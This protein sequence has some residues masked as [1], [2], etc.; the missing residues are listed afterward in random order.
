MTWRQATLRQVAEVDLGRQRAPEHETGP[1]MTRYLRAANVKDGRLELD[2]VLSMNFSPKEQVR[3]SLQHGDVL[4]TEGSGS[5][6][7]VGAS[8][9]YRSEFDG[10]ICFQNT[11]LRLRPRP[12]VDGRFLGWWTRSA[13]T[14]GL[15]AS[16][17]SGANIYHISAERVRGLRFS[18][19]SSEEQRR[20]ADFLDIETS[21]V[22][23]LVRL[24]FKQI[25]LLKE[26]H[27][28]RLDEKM[29]DTTTFKSLPLA[30]LTDAKRPIQY[31][32]VLPGPNYEN[33][34]PIL[35]GGDVAAQRVDPTKLSRTDPKIDHI[36]RRSR[37]K[38][39]D[40]VMAIRGSIG[41]IVRIP[42]KLNGA[43]LTQDTARIAPYNVDTNWLEAVLNSPSIQGQMSS[44]TTG[45]TIKGINIET[46][47]RIAI[48][49]PSR[50][51]QE[52]LGRWAMK[53]EKVFREAT[54]KIGKTVVALI[55]RRQ[56][57]IT[58]AVNGQLDVTTMRP[59]S[60]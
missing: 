46:L 1:N 50:I 32:I 27:A 9:V 3:F 49:T 2:D 36:Y 41:E 35:K 24:K 56:A 15:F 30:R 60:R 59:G 42:A 12:G 37:I 43:N 47:R 31:G 22:D 6:N 11:L 20:I 51:Q 45:A 17:A 26:C 38:E 58:A 52:S 10:T 48:P 57:L 4:V 25:E 13:F 28:A 14:S 16:I 55:E 29:C 40:L 39:G 53:E 21:R 5:L 7:A 44:M 33:G 18:I 23:N 8:A 34:V 19:P 54:E